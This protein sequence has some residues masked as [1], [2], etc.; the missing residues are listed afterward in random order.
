MKN[1]TFLLLLFCQQVQGQ[2][3]RLTAFLQ[4]SLDHYVARNL[5]Q[6]QIPGAAICVVHNNK[7]LLAKGYG[8]TDVQTKQPVDENTL[9]MIGS[10]TKA[11]TGTLMAMLE[12]EKMCNM[13]D[14]VQKWL[15]DFKMQDP[16]VAA[17]LN[18]TDIVTHRIGME[19]FQG[20]F[21]Y[22]TTN[23]SANEVI[24]H[25]GR[26]TPAYDFR[27]KWGYT[28]AGYVIA[29]AAIQSISGKSWADNLQSKLLTPLGMT[30]TLP[31]SAQ[32]P[33]ANN[34]ARPHSKIDGQL[35]VLDFPQIDNLAPAGS[36]ASSVNDMSHWLIAQ[37]NLGKYKDQQ[38]IPT[39]AIRRTRQPASI[40]GRSY[41]AGSNFML[42]G[43][44][45]F[46]TD[47]HGRE[48]VAHTGGVNGFVTAVT[49]IPEEKIGIVVL[50]NTDDNGFYSSM[51]DVLVNAALDRPFE[52]ISA[53]MFDEMSV[54]QKDQL[55]QENIWRDSVALNLTP[56]LPLSAY[57]GSYQNPM[58]GNIVL[59]AN[60]RQLEAQFEHHTM[61]ALLAPL[62]GN[63]FLCTYS[64]RIM[65]IKVW[66]FELKNGKIVGFTLTVNDFLEFTPYEFVK[67]E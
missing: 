33:K 13:N 18:L 10:N 22:W 66:P 47:K 2:S 52:D 12:Q 51:N 62:G 28:N 36:I 4:D 59:K 67:K 15:P 11:F 50:T 41:E 29:G 5:K 21:T 58:Y 30:R 34:M 63:R 45:W 7:V 16:W 37:L 64:D 27:T 32:L 24:E 65:G 60:G 25:F 23:L 26:F 19:T 61:T 56:A 35:K 9:F 49:L 14:R 3:A 46:L 55:Q 38:V 40:I 43:L 57:A 8:M 31:L 54:Q 44:G 1:L 17:H 53:I 20:D 39:A 6:W 42:Y 48:I